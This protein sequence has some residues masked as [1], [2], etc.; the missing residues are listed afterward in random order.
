[1]NLCRVTSLLTFD[2]TLWVGTGGGTLIMYDLI[3]P[4]IG[5]WSPAPPQPQQTQINT[6]GDYLHAEKLMEKVRLRTH[7][8]CTVYWRAMHS[9][10]S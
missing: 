9:V 4:G 3:D 6:G 8:T 10:Y 7:D 2:S 1:M 5:L